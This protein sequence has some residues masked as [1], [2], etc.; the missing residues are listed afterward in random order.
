L[1]EGRLLNRI[2]KDIGTLDDILPQTLFD[3]IEVASFTLFCVFK[4]PVV[5]TLAT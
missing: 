2:A 4:P 3:V 1:G 5:V